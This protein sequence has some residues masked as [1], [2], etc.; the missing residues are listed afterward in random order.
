MSLPIRELSE[1]TAIYRELATDAT[2]IEKFR[3]AK[4][5]KEI[6]LAKLGQKRT[7]IVHRKEK[8]DYDP[9]LDLEPASGNP[10]DPFD[11]PTADERREWLEWKARQDKYY[12]SHPDE[13]VITK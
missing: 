12:A 3:I 8:D 7:R 6:G 13:A 1:A 5:L 4:A 9:K 10:T 11:R 2:R